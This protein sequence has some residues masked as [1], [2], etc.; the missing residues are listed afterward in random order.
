MTLREKELLEMLRSHG[1]MMTQDE[2]AVRGLELRG[3]VV[4]LENGRVQC[5]KVAQAKVEIEP[6]DRIEALKAALRTGAKSPKDALKIV[7][8][9]RLLWLAVQEGDV[10][11]LESGNYG[12][13][14]GPTKPWVVSES[15]DLVRKVMPTGLPL[16]TADVMRRTGFSES[17]ARRLLSR[18][19]ETGELTR[20]R[21]AYIR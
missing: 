7:G 4:R 17:V 12:V 14:G 18:M 11:C 5:V 21:G 16:R 13:I 19:V 10:V 3:L 6:R 8:D 1:S 2:E 20:V 9:A 15:A